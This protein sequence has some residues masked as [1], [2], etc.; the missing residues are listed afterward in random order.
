MDCVSPDVQLEMARA[1]VQFR[2]AHR[3]LCD[4]SILEFLNHS[5]FA[6]A[7]T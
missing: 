6:G 3:M 2:T 7:A 1:H 4:E 5:H